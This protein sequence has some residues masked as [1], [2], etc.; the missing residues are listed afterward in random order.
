MTPEN[1]REGHS[2]AN[3]SHWENCLNSKNI[4]NFE[5]NVSP[6]SSS[7]HS[8]V[9]E[10]ETLQ[11]KAPVWMFKYVLIIT[12]IVEKGLWSPKLQHCFSSIIPFKLPC[13]HRSRDQH[14]S[15][16]KHPW[17][18]ICPLANEN[19]SCHFRERLPTSLP[20]NKKKVDSRGKCDMLGMQ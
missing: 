12:G 14:I 8:D 17:P 7:T 6:S 15:S 16:L 9:E 5:K 19:S 11:Q 18:S 3:F 13:L 2:K 20:L 10:K 1:K 4:K